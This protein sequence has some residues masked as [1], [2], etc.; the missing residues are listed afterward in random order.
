MWLRRIT[1]KGTQ[2]ALGLLDGK[3]QRVVH[4][5][6]RDRHRDRQAILTGVMDVAMDARRYARDG[7]AVGELIGLHGISPLEELQA[8]EA[9]GLIAGD[10]DVVDELDLDGSEAVL[11]LARHLDVLAARCDR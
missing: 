1:R 3:Q 6:L 2:R 10:E 8:G 7:L 11:D 5:V 4:A 9:D